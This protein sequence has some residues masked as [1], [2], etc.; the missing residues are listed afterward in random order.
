VGIEPDILSG[1]EISLSHIF[2]VLLV[3]IPFSKKYP[4]GGTIDF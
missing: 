3:I 4:N 1:N 2:A